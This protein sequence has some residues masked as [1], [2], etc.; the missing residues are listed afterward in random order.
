MFSL[1]NLN[2]CSAY[3]LRTSH[4]TA[5]RFLNFP[6]WYSFHVVVSSDTHWCTLCQNMSSGRFGGSLRTTVFRRS[7]CD[8]WLFARGF[9]SLSLSFRLS[10]SFGLFFGIF[11]AS[12]ADIDGGYQDRTQGSIC[13]QAYNYACENVA[14]VHG[15]YEHGMLEARGAAAS[16]TG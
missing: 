9:L 2:R 15:R 1:F 13:V 5:Y 16:F 7:V 11:A 10:L 4:I 6:W 14:Q 8:F 12:G 3:T